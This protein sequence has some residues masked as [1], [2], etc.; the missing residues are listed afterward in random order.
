MTMLDPKEVT[1]TTASGEERTYL[2]GKFPALPGLELVARLGS[3]A[4]AVSRDPQPAID[5]MA[6]LLAYVAVPGANGEPLELKTAALVN[7]HIP[8]WETGLRLIKEVAVYNT[9]FFRNE[10]ILGSLAG[11]A[12]TF[13]LKNIETLMASLD[14]SS[15]KAAPLSTS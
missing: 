14:Q 7:N 6:R 13:K 5:L 9:S 10:K 3:A 8:D 11:F 12:K 1:V 15:P 4:A 2:I